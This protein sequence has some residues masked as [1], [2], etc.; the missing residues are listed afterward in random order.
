MP[1]RV[2]IDAS[3]ICQLKCAG[4]GFQNGEGDGLGRGYL[5]FENFRKFCEMNPFIKDI[6]LSNY[7]EI[8]LNP[9]LID[10][11]YYAKER[12]ITLHCYNGA[13]FNTVSDEQIHALVDTGFKAISLSI[14]GASQETYSK[15]R[16]GG[17]FDRVIVNVKKLQELKKKT[18]SQFP[19]L[20]WQYLLME[21]NEL[22][23]GKAKK[24]AAELDIPI[25][26]KYNWDP[27]YEPVHRE[28]LTQQT[29]KKELTR[30]EYVATHEVGPYNGMCEKIFR[31]PQINWDGRMLG[32]SA[33]RYATFDVNVF[34]MSL[35]EAIRSPKYIAAKECLMTVHPDKEKYGT[36]VCFDCPTRKLRE[37]AEIEFKL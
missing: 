4:C 17:D 26:F 29:G 6:E 8:F 1:E 18:G 13:N 35:V 10:I 5:T 24:M 2:R 22:E 25:Y 34:E 37:K 36:C 23:I 9:D 31:T 33:K 32:C 12:G 28:Y 7:G 15:Y 16:I 14:D 19:E 3:T 21:H 11:M 30:A 27:T 20:R